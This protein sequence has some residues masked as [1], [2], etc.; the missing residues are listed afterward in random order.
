M[1]IDLEK[2][3]KFLR[4]KRELKGLTL[5]DVSHSLCIRKSLLD[6]M[7]S[8]NWKLLPHEVYVKGY[9]KEYAH[10]LEVYGEIFDDLASEVVRAPAEVPIQQ[11]ISPKPSRLSK[12]ALLYPLAFVLLVGLV[13]LS[14][15]Y[16]EQ[17][18]SG[19]MNGA[20]HVPARV[21]T[22]NTAPDGRAAPEGRIAETQAPE[23]KKLMITCLERTW[24]S[25][26]IDEKEKKEFMLNP[27][28]IVVLNAQDKYDLLIGNAAGVKLALNGN[29][30]QFGGQSGEVKRIKL[31]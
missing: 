16:R 9:V 4:E 31:P 18:L 12:R 30:V 25:V 26:V 27:Q 3:G 19:Q 6:A 22:S 20:G 13:I 2:I 15:I 21:D 17:P 10:L 8:G 14:Q 11:K 1:S 29:D 24:I 28:D 5:S 7:E 23:A